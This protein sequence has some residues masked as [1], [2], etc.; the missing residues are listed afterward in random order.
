MRQIE[1][2]R[3]PDSKPT[4]HAPR[5]AAAGQ[6]A[7]L[8]AG[9]AA[10]ACVAALTGCAVGGTL[11]AGAASGALEAVGL[12]PSNLP[13]SQK[14]PREVPLKLYAG[15]NLN[16]A[17]DNRPA[18]IVV[19]L[20]KL[21]DP[22]SFLQA[23]FD[24]F[25]DPQREQKT[26]GADLVQVREMTLIP[27]Q[28]YEIVEKITREAGTFGVVAL[29]RSPAPQRWKFAFDSARSEKSGVTIGLHACAMTL[30]VGDAITPA[31]AAA[32]SNLNLVSAAGCRT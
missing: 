10:A 30:T 18:A 4:G 26:L 3:A 22:T 17:A 23:P 20:Y 31:G 12:K 25:I 8:A 24:T 7:S 13:E 15:N 16:A 2:S 6:R 9:L 14:P 1:L 11:L 29:F 21:K 32:S 5:R 27:G 19:R 28:R